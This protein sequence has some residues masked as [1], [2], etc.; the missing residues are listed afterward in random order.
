MD[1]MNTGRK[2]EVL[3]SLAEQLRLYKAKNGIDECAESAKPLKNRAAVLICIFQGNEGDLRVILTQRA[4]TMSSHSGEVALPGGK[5]DEADADY[6]ETAL[7]EA[8]EEIGLDPSL[9]HVVA[10]LE[11]FVTLRGVIVVPVVGILFDKKAYDPVPNASE[12]ESIF[13]VP[14]EM[15]LKNENRRAE[16]KE[17]MGHN[18]LLHHFDYQSG[19]RKYLIWALTAGILIQVASIV[20]QRPPAF[21]EQRP[22]FWTIIKPSTNNTPKL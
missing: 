13:D 6:V 20:Y 12:V 19:T 17:R 4:S 15:F 8:Q 21:S 7:R 5:R 1:S 18:Y 10:V 9:V 11:P 16:E 22:P 14:L 3:V 2:S